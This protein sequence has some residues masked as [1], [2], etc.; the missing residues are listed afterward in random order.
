MTVHKAKGLEFPVVILGDITARLTPFDASRYLDAD[1][2]LCALRI[3]GWSPKELNDNRDREILREQKEG[4]RIAYVAATRARDLLV[5]P[6]VGDEPYTE[7]WVAPLN[8]AVYPPDDRRRTQ[9]HAIG[10]PQFASKDSVLTRPDGDPATRSTVCPG[11]HPGQWNGSPYSVVWWSPE[12]GV[13]RLKEEAPFGLRREDL[14]VKNVDPD[15]LRDH[16]DAYQTWKARR[17]DAIETAQQPS[18]AVMTATEASVEPGT[19]TDVAV[20]VET[21]DGA[22]RSAWRRA[23]R[24]AGAC[25]AGRCAARRR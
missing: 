20:S 3:G 16:L 19:S 1:R 17:R 7:G 2:G 8:V 23:I 6:A 11:E 21:V 22:A 25:A 9:S 14:I 24:I 12:P 4:E 13:L 10:C 18:I 5:V 15:V